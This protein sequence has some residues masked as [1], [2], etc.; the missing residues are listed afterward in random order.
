MS[1]AVILAD[2]YAAQRGEAYPESAMAEEIDRCARV[3][4]ADFRRFPRDEWLAMGRAAAWEAVMRYRNRGNGV[5]GCFAYAYRWVQYTYL[6]A[7]RRAA[8]DPVPLSYEPEAPAL[9]GTAHSG[10]PTPRETYVRALVS[11]LGPKSSRIIEATYGIGEPATDAELAEELNTTPRSVQALRCQA[12]ARLRR[13][14][15]PALG[16]QTAA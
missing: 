10:R 7:A 5:E 6:A 8:Q 13:L 2:V 16:M 3:A 15:R 14:A 9:V 1:R 12:T 4:Y 11:S